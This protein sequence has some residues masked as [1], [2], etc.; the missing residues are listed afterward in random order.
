VGA[1]VVGPVPPGQAHT[2]GG[3]V[4]AV[5]RVPVA[6][7]RTAF[8][9]LSLRKPSNPFRLR[10]NVTVSGAP[11]ARFRRAMRQSEKSAAGLRK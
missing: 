9:S 10:S 11:A 4:H 3:V 5:P 8:R 2:L 6:L 1:A 7:P